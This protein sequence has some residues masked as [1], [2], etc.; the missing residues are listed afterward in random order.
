M[1]ISVL[2]KRLSK[3]KELFKSTEIAYYQLIGQLV[4]LEE[5]IKLEKEQQKNTQ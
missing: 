4:L 3:T 5:L 2:E 1:E